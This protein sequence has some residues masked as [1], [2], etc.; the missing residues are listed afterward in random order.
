MHI[1]VRVDLVITQDSATPHDLI[2]IKA[3]RFLSFFRVPHFVRT[4]RASHWKRGNG[5]TVLEVVE[6][7][8]EIHGVVPYSPNPLRP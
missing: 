3:Q 6:A 8:S 7:L 1:T 4:H 5:V 2:L